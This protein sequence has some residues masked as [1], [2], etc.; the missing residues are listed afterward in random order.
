L[1]SGHKNLSELKNYGTLDSFSAWKGLVNRYL[2]K[3]EGMSPFCESFFT[4]DSFKKAIE[5]RKNF[6]VNRGILH[7]VLD[8]QHREYYERFPQVASCVNAISDENTFTVTTG[9]QLCLA[10]GPLFFIYKIAS[11]V[12]TAR[13]ISESEKINCIPVLWLASE[14]HDI[15][16]IS[17]LHL[18]GKTVKYKGA[19]KGISG[20]LPTNDLQEFADELS[21]IL[22]NSPQAGQWK[23]WLNEPLQKRKHLAD[24]VRDWVL[25]LFAEHGLLVLDANHPELKRE[26]A[27]IA[28]REIREEI[29]FREVSQTSERIK[30]ELGLTDNELPL[31]ARTVNWFYIE[32]DG[33]YRI[34]KN[35]SAYELHHHHRK[36]TAEELLNEIEQHPRKFSPNVILRP[37]YQEKILPNLSYIGGP[38]ELSYWLLL[39]STFDAHRVY[40]PV[41][42][43]RASFFQTKEKNLE[44]LGQL[45]FSHNDLLKPAEELQHSFLAK[46]N[47]EPV[48]IAEEMKQLEN[49][50]SNLEERA[51]QIDKGL[52]TN[53]LAEKQKSLNALQQIE[54]KINKSKK[55][56]FDKDLQ[57]I[58]MM[59]DS[60][61][62]TG[63]PQE[64]VENVLPYLLVLNKEWIN[65]LIAQSKP[66][67][68]SFKS[69]IISS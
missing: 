61:F 52:I 12:A 27:E 19:Y 65:Y 55:Q 42:Q 40:F 11:A 14:D 5:R 62:P 7:Q 56:T 63:L 9:H 64:R 50:F 33:R 58:R 67:F 18:F 39:K 53:I 45:G 69:A 44:R 24:V 30:Q 36:F 32:E 4:E 35:E 68:D 22:G 3:E 13:F 48:V 49:L 21:Q 20:R 2:N 59:K 34:D 57:F 60:F 37:L 6:P 43:P 41:L 25:E 16:E 10:T 66:Q 47:F 17:A 38:G 51:S 15:E 29:S 8:E 28:K 54:A 31:Q 26:L 23:K 46:N 1:A